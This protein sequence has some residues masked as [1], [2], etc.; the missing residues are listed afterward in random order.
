MTEDLHFEDLKEFIAEPASEDAVQTNI[1][2]CKNCV[3][4]IE[5][6][7]G[8]QTGCKLGRIE[9]YRER[10][11]TIV[12]ARNEESEFYGIETWCNA[13]RGEPWGI[14]NK[15]E[16]LISLVKL[17]TTP[18]VSFIVLVKDSVDGF[19]KTIDSILNQNEA[20]TARIVVA[21]GGREADVDYLELI[22]KCNDLLGGKID[23]KVQNLMPDMSQEEIIDEAFDNL[24]NGYYSIVECG[25]EVPEDLIQVLH[26]NLHDEL[27]NVGLV[28]AHDGINGLTVQCVLHKF[29]VGN[30]G[31]SIETKL[32]EG[33]EYDRET[34]LRE[35]E[36]RPKEEWTSLKPENSLIHTWDDLR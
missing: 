16:D 34:Y 23:Y 20:K 28:K 32:K 4:S 12:E 6:E 18:N 15:D 33:E 9:K 22:H 25:K 3:F 11:V 27:K 2:S 24:V 21:H 17:E 26:R 35:R 19:E 36:L 30:N 1:T 7:E 8:N 13:Y 5:N 29:L 14:A 10:G 31:A